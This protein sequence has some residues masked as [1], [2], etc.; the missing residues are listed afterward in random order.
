MVHI[1]CIETALQWYIAVIGR[2]P[3][4][5]LVQILILVPVSG[6]SGEDIRNRGAIRVPHA[7]Q[8]IHE[9]YHPSVPEIVSGGG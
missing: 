2:P 3:S 4:L 6:R 7:E 1:A 9:G 8:G 5:G